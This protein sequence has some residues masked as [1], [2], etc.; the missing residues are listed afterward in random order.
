MAAS[1]GL[2]AGA[3]TAVI[4]RL[5]TCEPFE[6]RRARVGPGCGSKPLGSRRQ[7]ERQRS[8]RRVAN[9]DDVAAVQ[10]LDVEPGDVA[11]QE[12]PFTGR[13]FT[14]SGTCVPSRSTASILAARHRDGSSASIFRRRSFDDCTFHVVSTNELRKTCDVRIVMPALRTTPTAASRLNAA[15]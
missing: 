15:A 13:E 14:I 3:M 10:A 12:P 11:Q 2:R 6:R 5:R 8:G 4:A 7:H 1:A 9:H